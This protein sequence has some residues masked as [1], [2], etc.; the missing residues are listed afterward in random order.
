MPFSFYKKLDFFDENILNLIV[1]QINGD[2]R[3]LIFNMVSN[4]R[5]HFFLS[6]LAS[7]YPDPFSKPTLTQLTEQIVGEKNLMMTCDP[8]Q[9]R[10]LAMSTIFRGDMPSK[11]LDKHF[12][13][14]QNLKTTLYKIPPGDLPMSATFIGNN[15][16]IPKMFRNFLE[17]F[18][19]MIRRTKDSTQ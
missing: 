13:D 3:K 11:E 18:S 8:R 4:P 16:I 2:S 17:K 7:I 15:T 12:S 9:G 6:N 10:Y 19:V 14:Y 1:E 5:L